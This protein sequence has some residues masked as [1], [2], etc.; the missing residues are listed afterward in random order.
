MEKG[1]AQQPGGFFVRKKR[2]YDTTP[3]FHYRHYF[4][5]YRY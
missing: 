5:S 3:D 1:T 4:G 2:K